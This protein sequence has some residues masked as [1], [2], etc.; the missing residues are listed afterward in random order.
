MNYLEKRRRYK[1]KKELRRTKPWLMGDRLEQ[2]VD[3]VLGIADSGVMDWATLVESGKPTSDYPTKDSI[4]QEHIRSVAREFG[5]RPYQLYWFFTQKLNKLDAA[6]RTKSDY[7]AV[8]RE[9]ATV[10]LKK[11]MSDE[12]K[13]T[14]ATMFAQFANTPISRIDAEIMLDEGKL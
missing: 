13:I 5:V 2:E 1:V 6:G 3:R 10:T 9:C 14:A 4:K 8:L 12:E 7:M 11:S